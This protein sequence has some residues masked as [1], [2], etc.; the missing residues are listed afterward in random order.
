MRCSEL[1]PG[2]TWG[3]YEEEGYVGSSAQGCCLC[4]LC[5]HLGVCPVIRVIGGAP[6]PPTVSAPASWYRPH[7]QVQDLLERTWQL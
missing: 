4:P 2:D 7:R 5:P 1:S 3:Q 6:P